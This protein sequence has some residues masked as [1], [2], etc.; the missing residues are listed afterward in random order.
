MDIKII[1]TVLES[2][3]LVAEEKIRKL[4]DKTS[5]I[6]IDVI[7]GEF[8]PDKSFEIE[9][10]S[11]LD[12]ESDRLLWDMHLM[13]KEPE[14]WVNKCQFVG[15]SR[16]VGQVELMTDRKEFIGRVKDLGME[17]GLAF[18]I[19]TEIDGLI[20]E[21]T[22]LVLLMGRKAG[23]GDCQL[24]KKVLDKMR[25]LK[26]QRGPSA[27]QDDMLVAIDGGVNK[28]NINELVK[29]GVDIIY[30]GRNYLE[31]KNEN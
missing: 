7:D 22:D 10:L 1:P 21:E 15:A 14:K 30:S 6:Q 3:F 12:F 20:P 16:V 29:A 9:L 19:D 2:D 18:D 11:K 17:A 23:F 24:D 27:V 28:D 8:A 5:W 25:I 13:V 26:S 4:K 31:L